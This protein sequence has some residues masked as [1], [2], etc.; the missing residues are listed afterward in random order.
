[1]AMDA[2]LM[3]IAPEFA[4]GDTVIGEYIHAECLKSGG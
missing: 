4:I 2:A 1:M 3:A